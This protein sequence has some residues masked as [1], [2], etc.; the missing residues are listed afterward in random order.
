MALKT[1]P[2]PWHG[3]CGV[4][5]WL[6]WLRNL[7]GLMHI[8]ERGIKSDTPKQMMSISPCTH[9]DRYFSRGWRSWYQRSSLWRSLTTRRS[10]TSDCCSS[11]S[12]SKALFTRS[13]CVKHQEW[14]LWEQVMLF[15]LSYV[16]IL[17]T[18]RQR[19][20]RIYSVIR[21]TVDRFCV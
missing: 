20:K 7:T 11:R 1:W 10:S 5:L 21:Y 13:V 14:V 18:A 16:Y 12:V 17:R 6:W 4:R 8:N 9:F 15:I 2:S 19:S 3:L